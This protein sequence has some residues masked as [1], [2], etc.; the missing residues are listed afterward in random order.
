MTKYKAKRVVIDTN[1]ILDY[2]LG[3]GSKSHQEAIKLIYNS[4]IYGLC[5]GV[6]TASTLTDLFYILDGA[7]GVDA[8]R[9]VKKLI[10]VHTVLTVTEADCLQALDSTMTDFE[11][12]VLAACAKRNQ[13]D[14]LVTTNTADFKSSGLIVYAVAEFVHQLKRG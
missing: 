4:S 14:S 6:I 11:D 3:R 13:I 8:R 1:V 10:Q 5:E 7:A 12:A 2:L 9:E